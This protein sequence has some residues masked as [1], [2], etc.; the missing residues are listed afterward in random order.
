MV[1]KYNGAQPPAVKL[2]TPK[3]VVDLKPHL[4]SMTISRTTSEISELVVSIDD[5]DFALVER[6]GK[7][8][9]ASV[10]TMSL[11]YIV[12][13]MD[14]DSGGGRG[15]MTLN[16]RPK[17]VRDLKNRR[18][19][20]V[21][22]NV[23]PTQ[24]VEREVKAVGGKFVGQPSP[25]RARVAREVTSN[26]NDEKPSSWTT[27]R[28]L[29][30]S[31]GY[32]LYEDGGVYYFGKPTWLI[33]NVGRMSV[34]YKHSDQSLRPTT[35]PTMSASMDEPKGIEWSFAMGVEHAEDVR[36]GMRVDLKNFPVDNG[37]YLLT[38]MEHPIYG[39][40]SDLTL[41]L[42]KPV[43]PEVTKAAT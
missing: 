37:G 2:V 7:P 40:S 42:A 43:D 18:G 16:C 30:E 23:S 28:S 11:R 12:D 35:L 38:S 9:G 31:L 39:S 25:R 13:S 10:N 15:G 22:N 36:P 34:N 33:N 6:Y 8:L 5:P 17:T 14:L 20:F 41:S 27:M 21:M 29:A 26:S 3:V 19:A 24:W 1:V 4:I 32:W